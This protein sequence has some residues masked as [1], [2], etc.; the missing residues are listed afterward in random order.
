M[1]RIQNDEVIP[2]TMEEE[3]ERKVVFQTS[4]SGWLQAKS[5][6][7]KNFLNLIEKTGY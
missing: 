3:R 4:S 6:S 2:F 1:G 7:I 5:R